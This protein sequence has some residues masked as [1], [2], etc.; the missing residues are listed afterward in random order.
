VM[1][2]SGTFAW[3]LTKHAQFVHL[4]YCDGMVANSH[5]HKDS[6]TMYI[7]KFHNKTEIWFRS[8]LVSNIVANGLESL[9][10]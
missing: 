7:I 10:N 1:P 3:V 9:P 6:M 5:D 4:C 2:V 8:L